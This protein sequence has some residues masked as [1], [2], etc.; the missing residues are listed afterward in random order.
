MM[1]TVITLLLI[2]YPGICVRC[3]LVL[4]CVQVDGLAGTNG[5]SGVV[6]MSDYSVECWQDHHN[7]YATISFVCIGLFVVGIPLGVLTTLWYH[8][9]HLYDVKSPR[10]KEVIHEFGTLYLQYEPNFWYWEVIVIFKKMILTGV[11]CVV[12]AGSSAQLVIALLVVLVYMQL[13]LKL[14]PFVDNTDDW[15]SF[16]TSFQLLVTLLGGLLLFTALAVVLTPALGLCP[17]AL[18]MCLN[19]A[20]NPFRRT[21]VSS[22]SR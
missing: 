16:T 9:R 2:M 21:R 19:T 22:A 3:F 20:V 8:K 11:M 14:A 15:L 17:F 1:K 10:H 5:H 4:K 6:L 7:L 12:G 18:G 13:V